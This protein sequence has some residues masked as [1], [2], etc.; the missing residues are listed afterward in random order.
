M[1]LAVALHAAMKT[2]TL[3]LMENLALR[4]QLV[5]LRRSTPKRHRLKATDRLSWIGISRLCADWRTWLVIVQPETVV[6][7]HRT[8][9]RAF[10]TC[11]IRHGKP[12]RPGVPS[13][14]R[15]PIRRIS[16]ENPTWGAPR[17]HG[18]LLK[19]GIE[20]AE[21]SVS[22]YLV[23]ARLLRPRPGASS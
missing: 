10:W 18:E 5:V 1:E 14:T 9:F 8:L 23:R 19:L 11:K 22:K 20:I 4:H 13:D 3:L 16:R 15:E 2:R 21:S 6:G 12:G 7:W 17:I